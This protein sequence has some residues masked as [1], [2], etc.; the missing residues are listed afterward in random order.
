MNG[1]GGDVRFLGCAEDAQ[2]CDAGRFECWEGGRA[3]SIKV[4]VTAQIERILARELG[5]ED[6]TREERA[7]ILEVGGRHMLEERLR[8]RRPLEHVMYLD[9]R[10]F[11]TAGA[12]KALLHESGL[13]AR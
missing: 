9:S 3:V 4:R 1:G 2:D 10:I 12:E 11:L 6:L 5:R 7:S 13:L 8:S